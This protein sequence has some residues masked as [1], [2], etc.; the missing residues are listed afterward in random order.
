[1]ASDQNNSGQHFGF[2]WRLLPDVNF[3]G[4]NV[5]NP[6][7]TMALYPRLNSGSA[8]GTTD[9]NAVTSSQTYASPT[10]SEYTVQQ[11]TGEVYTRLRGRQLAFKC[12]SC[13]LYTSD[14]ADE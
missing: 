9:L 11:F 6:Q 3:N 12:Y 14:A 8:Y 1:M 5:A 4:S 7:V 10:P 13:L 2:V